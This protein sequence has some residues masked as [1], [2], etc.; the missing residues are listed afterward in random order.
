MQAQ[1]QIKQRQLLE[2]K[3]RKLELEL[4]ATQ[5]QLCQTASTETTTGALN[6]SLLTDSIITTSSLVKPAVT[7]VP[8]ITMEYP[9]QTV[10]KSFFL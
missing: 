8:S 2:L 3:K 6:A 1:L 7:A 5:K 4:A 9:I 10:N